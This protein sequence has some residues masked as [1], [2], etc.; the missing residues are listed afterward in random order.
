M[1][2]PGDGKVDRQGRRYRRLL[3]FPASIRN[4]APR[5]RV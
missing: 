5:L 4:R 3:R 1:T 2:T